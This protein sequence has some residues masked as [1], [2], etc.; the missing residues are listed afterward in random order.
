MGRR[1][2][3][4]PS[5]HRD[6][7][8]R[9]A[10]QLFLEKGII[11][12]TM[13][14]IAKTAKYSKATLYVYFK[15]KE[16]IIGVLT[17]ESMNMLHKRIE[18]AIANCDNTR[19]RYQGICNDLTSYQQEFPLYFELALRDINVDFDVPGALPVEQEIFKVGELIVGEIAEFLN[20]G[21]LEKVLRMDILIPQ[22]VFLFWAS[23]SGIIKMAVKKQYY[24]QK[25]MGI[26]KQQFLDE[27]FNTLFRSI[28]S[29][30]GGIR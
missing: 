6:C 12:A 7:I 13:D 1:K 10:K 4:E 26:T 3:E 28:C 29:D 5:F 19:E 17:L 30:E 2:K 15:N 14:D 22:T 9:A 18:A 8:I 23:L 27:S 16:E 25:T 21:I 20:K 11:A 24:I